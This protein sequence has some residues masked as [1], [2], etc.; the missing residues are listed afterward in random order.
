MEHRRSSKYASFAMDCDV[1][2]VSVTDS[3]NA[4]LAQQLISTGLAPEHYIASQ[5]TC[6]G[7]AGR[8]H[9]ASENETVWIGSATTPLIEGMLRL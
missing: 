9:A 5:G 8:I 1:N 4:G 7:R 2:K 6:L 3:L